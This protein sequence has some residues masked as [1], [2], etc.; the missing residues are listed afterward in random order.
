[1]YIYHIKIQNFHSENFWR[2][3]F[4]LSETIY[5]QY[6]QAFTS[7]SSSRQASSSFTSRQ[8]V[9]SN[10]TSST[11]RPE[12]P[13]DLVGK[14]ISF[15]R[16]VTDEHGVKRTETR[17]EVDYDVMKDPN[18]KWTKK[19]V[20][21][22]DGSVTYVWEGEKVTTETVE[23]EPQVTLGNV[24]TRVVGGSTTRTVTTKTSSFDFES[25]QNSSASAKATAIGRAIFGK[26][27]DSDDSSE[28]VC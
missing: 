4:L 6:F 20:V 9:T 3:F 25:N 12:L 18:I 11:E 14:E 28:E 17:G 16:E 15:T 13:S 26:Q 7:S 23:V 27:T 19:E 5:N 24:E 2:I 22:E 1:M 21:G 8:S 10:L